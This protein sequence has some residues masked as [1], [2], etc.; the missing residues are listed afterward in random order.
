MF[1]LKPKEGGS[2]VATPPPDAT[3]NLLMKIA[4]VV[5]IVAIA[6]VGYSG[7]STR[8]ALEEKIATLETAHEKDVTDLQKASTELGADINVVSKKLGVTTQDLDASR[9]YAERLRQE[10]L[11][12]KEQLASEL[13]TKANSTDV[14][15]VAQDTS[16]N[17]R[18]YNR[19]PTQRLAASLVK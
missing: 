16:T 12:A 15:A 7:Y 17:W 8:L 4:L 1:S 11:Q 13:A 18:P 5:C 19:T 10:Q 3:G 2:A 14:A 6:A 9:K